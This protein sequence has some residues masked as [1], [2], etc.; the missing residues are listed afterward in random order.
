MK[1]IEF[2]TYFTLARLWKE[3][4]FPHALLLS[5]KEGFGGLPIAINLVQYMFCE[6]KNDLYACGICS[7]CS[8]TKKLAHPDLHLSFPVIKPANDKQLSRIFVKEFRSYILKN[9]FSTYLQWMQEINA[10]NKQGKISADECREIIEELNLKS[11]EGR[12]KV[13]IIWLPEYMGREG[14]ILLKL[15]E[16]PPADTFLI[17]ITENEERMLGTIL[18]RT[19]IVKLPPVKPEQ[20][21][22]MLVERELT[23]HQQAIQIGHLA[24][25]NFAEAIEMALHQDNILLPQAI[26]WL[27][28][29]FT[30]NGGMIIASVEALSGIGREE[31]K[32][33]YRY[34][35]HLLELLIRKTYVPEIDIA[36]NSEEEKLISKLTR[37]QLDLEVLEEMI[38]YISEAIYAITRNAHVKTIM[39]A[40]AIQCVRSLRKAQLS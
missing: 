29:V 19:Q 9:P 35:I 36:V 15:I 5:G 39:H 12:E 25:G 11:Y 10:E 20:I 30:N 22:A 1:P 8:K 34:L 33:F 4:K 24:E 37:Q 7:S 3:Q 17:L 40:L 16:E 28:G 38:Q 6:Q 21:A 31:Q 18:S 32:N 26:N 14:N 13:Q 27:N 2:P 23:D